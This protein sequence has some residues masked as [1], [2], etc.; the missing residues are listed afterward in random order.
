MTLELSDIQGGVLHSLP[1]PYT[2]TFNL[3]RVDEPAAARELLGRL[4]PALRSAANPT[5]PE[6][7][8]WLSVAFTYQGLRRIGVPQASLDS[9]PAEFREGM[10]ARAARLHDVG[11]SAPQNWAQPYGTPD[12]HIALS[13][14]APDQARLDA[15]LRRF[16]ELLV[17]PGGVTPIHRMDCRSSDGREPFGFK[18]NIG[19]PPVE[20][21]GIPGTNPA[22]KPLQPGEF[23]LGY[24]DETG[25]LPPAPIPDMLGHN[26]SYLVVRVLRQ[27][28]AAFRR[29][30]RDNAGAAG[31]DLLAAKIMGRWRSGTPLALAPDHDDP[32]LVGNNAFGFAGDERGFACPAGSHVRRVNPRDAPIF[33]DARRHRLIRR[34]AVYGEP[35][36]EG[37]LDDDGV[38]RG[39]LFACVGASIRRQFEFVQEEWINSGVFIGNADERDPLCG[40]NGGT[41]RFTVPQRPIR[42]RVA[43][44]PS[45]VVTRGGE[46]FFMPG[47]RALRWL[48]DLP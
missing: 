31:E 9:F 8:A 41:G 29:Y 25:N 24:P 16:E 3:L 21:S 26:G 32:A 39:M 15:M 10:A 1:T 11:D 46:Y 27:H 23:L 14:M 45:F 5:S 34:E 33:G 20:G 30:L 12:V 35:L 42:R 6:A 40:A 37:V 28:V 36:P 13:A 22:E 4:I 19:Q 43:G 44:L 17:R 38:E 2:G 48:A 18:D 47:L 7:D